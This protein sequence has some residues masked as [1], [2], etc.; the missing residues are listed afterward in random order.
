MQ[1]GLMQL[2]LDSLQADIGETI[3]QSDNLTVLI[4]S[5]NDVTH[6]YMA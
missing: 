4:D 1:L 3:D 6:K 5:K 2:E